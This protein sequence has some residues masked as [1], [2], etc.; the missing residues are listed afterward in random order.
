MRRSP[1]GTFSHPAQPELPVL[2]IEVAHSQQAKDP[3]RLA[4]SDTIDSSH[5]IRAVLGLK[6]PYS[7]PDRAATATLVDKSAC[8]S[9]WRP[10]VVV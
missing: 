7:P 1:D 9:I 5:A 8:F 6:I 2:V 4:D 3:H 10:A